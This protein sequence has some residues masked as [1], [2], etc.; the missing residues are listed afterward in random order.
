MHICKSLILIPAALSIIFFSCQQSKNDTIQQDSGLSHAPEDTVAK[1][2]ALTESVYSYTLFETDG[3]GWGYKIFDNGTLIINQPHI[4][5]ISGNQGFST[6]EKA[7]ITAGY[8]IHKMELGF[9]PPTISVA[10][11]DSLGV[12]N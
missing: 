2:P 7:E 1:E 3:K 5:A 8:A 9:I 12:L 10:E 11:L 6:S 4:P